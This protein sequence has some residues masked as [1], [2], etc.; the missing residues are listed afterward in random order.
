MLDAFPDQ[1]E[2]ALVNGFYLSNRGVDGIVD[3]PKEPGNL[4]NPEECIDLGNERDDDF[5]GHERASF[6]GIVAGV[7][8]AVATVPIP[9]SRAVVPYSGWRFRQIPDKGP[10]LRTVFSVALSRDRA[11]LAPTLLR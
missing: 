4:V 5:S 9:E 8:R 11:T 2:V 3:C 1:V 7:D 6:E 10:V